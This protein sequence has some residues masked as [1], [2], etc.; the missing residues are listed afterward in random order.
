MDEYGTLKLGGYGFSRSIAD[1]DVAGAEGGKAR[2]E[3]QTRDPT[4]MAPELLTG[5]EDALSFASDF[6]ALGCVLFELLTGEPPFRS[7]QSVPVEERI[8]REVRL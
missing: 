1:V 3:W 2:V 4:Y 5:G 8:M 6:W 7:S